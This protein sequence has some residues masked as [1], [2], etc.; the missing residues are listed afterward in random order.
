METREENGLRWVVWV[1]RATV[2]LP[3]YA[4]TP[5]AGVW[6]LTPSARRRVQRGYPLGDRRP[7]RSASSEADVRAPILPQLPA[8]VRCPN[9]DCRKISRLEAARLNAVGIAPGRRS[10]VWVG[11]QRRRKLRDVLF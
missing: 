4:P 9:P 8:R 3:G 7:Y 2:L 6:D 10:P 11:G 1:P 5:H